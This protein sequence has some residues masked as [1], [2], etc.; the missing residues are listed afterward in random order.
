MYFF[1]GGSAP[2]SAMRTKQ[3]SHPVGASL[4]Q[5]ATLRRLTCGCWSLESRLRLVA[6][7][8]LGDEGEGDL[9]PGVLSWGKLEGEDRSLWRQ[10]RDIRQHGEPG[11][12]R[13]APQ[14]TDP[15]LFELSTR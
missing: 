12:L 8:E 10:Q 13:D 7:F 4:I 14:C 6:G 3:V 2:K 15:E 5:T 11:R 1:L 9:A